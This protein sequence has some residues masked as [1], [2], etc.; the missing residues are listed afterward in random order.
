V[1]FK[2]QC[3]GC[4]THTSDNTRA[5]FEDE[6]CP[7]CGLSLDAYENIQ[8]ARAGH[9]DAALKAQFEQLTVRAEVAEAE[10]DRLRRQIER[11]RE[12]LS[13]EDD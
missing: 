2:V 3:P 8:A 11:A 5:L 9:A 12:A 10:R 1:G 4:G 6:A 7:V 13:D